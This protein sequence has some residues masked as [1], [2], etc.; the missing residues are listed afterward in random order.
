MLFRSY[1][2]LYRI[3]LDGTGLQL[4]TPESA[5]HEIS[6]SESG[7]YFTDIY[8][9]P[10]LAPRAVV[11]NRA[12]EITLSLEQTDLSGLLASG[13]VAPI[14][15]T[16][17]ARDQL[18]D[19]HGLLYKPSNFDASQSYPILNYLYPGPQTG[20]VGTRSF[21]ASR[22]DKQALEIG[23]ASCRERG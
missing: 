10:T 13:W 12:G 11:R 20:S 3:N 15:F 16:A 19:L 7:E 4:L 6:W 2:Y 14:P 17:K 9:A 18:S 23:R 5:N 8:S 22:A 1:R 21:R